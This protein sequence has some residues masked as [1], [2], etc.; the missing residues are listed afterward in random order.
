MPATT[1]HQRDAKD[2]ANEM[3]DKHAAEMQLPQGEHVT[4]AKAQKNEVETYRPAAN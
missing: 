3:L 4:P 2:Q 1:N